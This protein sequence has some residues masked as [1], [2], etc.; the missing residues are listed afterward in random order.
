MALS[1]YALIDLDELKP[2]LSIDVVQAGLDTLLEGIVGRASE[3]IEKFLARQ[4]VTRGSRTEYH[5]I[6]STGRDTLLLAQY[7]I[8]TLTSVAEGSWVAGTWTAAATLAEGTDFVKHAE[9][10]RLV[11]ISGAWRTGHESVKVVYAAG[12]A[13][14]ALVP[15]PIKDVCLSLCARKYSQI[16]RGG[17]FGA[18]T[19]S[20]AVG[21]VT[22][23][24]PSELLANEQAS[25]AP[26]RNA[27]YATTGRV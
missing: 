22:R 26:W 11:R 10:G 14:T 6:D 23:F 20:D 12:Y 16:R 17:D 8:A 13:T 7:P 1:T 3:T 25:L 2:V 27:D 4:I 19:I 9:V 5:T 15:G 18:S 21:S 24:L